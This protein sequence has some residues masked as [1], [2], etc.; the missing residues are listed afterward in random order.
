MFSLF[1]NSGLSLAAFLPLG[2]GPERLNERR[3]RG[4]LRGNLAGARGGRELSGPGWRKD[5]FLELSKEDGENV[6]DGL[7]GTGSRRDLGLDSGGTSLPEP[8]PLG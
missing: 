7:R 4:G 3:Q 5:R 8:C 2:L 1:D 6:S